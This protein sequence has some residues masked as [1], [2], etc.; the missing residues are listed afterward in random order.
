M[1]VQLLS[2]GPCR[3]P[4]PHVAPVSWQQVMVV[5]TKQPPYC[6]TLFAST[7]S[8]YFS[9]VFTFLNYFYFLLYLK[10]EYFSCKRTHL[11]SQWI[12]QGFPAK[13]FTVIKSSVLFPLP[14]G[15][16]S[17][18]ADWCRSPVES[19]PSSTSL[20]ASAT[21]PNVLSWVKSSCRQH[22]AT[23]LLL[24]CCHDLFSSVCKARYCSFLILLPWLSLPLSHFPPSFLWLP[25]FLLTLFFHSWNWH[26]ITVAVFLPLY[27]LRW[28]VFSYLSTSSDIFILSSVS[29]SS[30]FFFC[31]PFSSNL[32]WP[33]RP[34]G[35]VLWPQPR[36]HRLLLLLLPALP[37]R[38]LP[39]LLLL[40][41]PALHSAQWDNSSWH[42][43]QSSAWHFFPLL[44][45]ITA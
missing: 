37:Y 6:M 18:V 39:L 21:W 27:L 13:H 4:E 26:S 9:H 31:S 1:V 22:A 2:T 34:A 12:T 15:G 16:I 17:V 35:N 43:I 40:P 10:F 8:T 29:F 36:W 20:W 32:L 3:S 28:L 30:S 45:Q 38:L 19:D 7:T 33:L 25:S 23:F 11:F 14:A 24:S 5:L 41:P 42:V 44:S